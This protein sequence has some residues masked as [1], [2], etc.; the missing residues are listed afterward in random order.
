MDNHKEIQSLAINHFSSMANSTHSDPSDFLFGLCNNQV[1][2][3]MNILLTKIL[4]AE[5]IRSAVFALKKDSS[6]GPDGFSRHFFTAS[7]HI[8]G[9]FVV[10]EMQQFFLSGKL[11]KASNAYF[12]TLIPKNK[13]HGSFVESS[14][15]SLLNFTYK[16]IAKTLASRV[17]KTPSH[18]ISPNQ[19]AFVQGRPIHQ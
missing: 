2:A 1:S 5:E 3:N 15:I 12:Q 16:I 14:L 17:F 8:I 18:L 4:D 9:S 11:H 10:R 7:W 13:S 6:P 19:A